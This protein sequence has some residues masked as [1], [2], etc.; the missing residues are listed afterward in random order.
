MRA[1]AVSAGRCPRPLL[2]LANLR[3]RDCAMLAAVRLRLPRLET[4]DLAG[5]E[6]LH[7][8]ELSAPR[9]RSARLFGCE[10]LPSECVARLAGTGA[11]V[12]WDQV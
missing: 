3:M 10:L 6:G 7:T 11:V 9:L 2:R 1:A 8:L 12:R 5:C 4:I